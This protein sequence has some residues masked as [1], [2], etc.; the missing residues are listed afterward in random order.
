MRFGKY[1]AVKKEVNGIK[2]DSTG[3]ANRY[4][5]LLLEERAGKISG[6]QLKPRFLLQEGFEKFGMK[7]RPIYYI[8]DFAYEENG[9]PVVEDYKG[10]RTEVFNIKAK[11]FDYKYP[12]FRLRI[13]K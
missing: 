11:I 13:T 5:E 8:A 4:S 10:V 9:L 6:L 12:K 2:F 7:T 3:E 1:N